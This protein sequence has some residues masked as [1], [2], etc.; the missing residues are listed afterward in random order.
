MNSIFILLFK[1]FYFS[2]YKFSHQDEKQQAATQKRIM[3]AHLTQD[4]DISVWIADLCK[5]Q[6]D[7]VVSAANTMLQHC[8]G[9]ALV[10]SECGG[11]KIQKEQ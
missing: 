3:S 2:F 11:P 8:G 1:V 9:L 10:I 7:A 4:V 6:V 5:F